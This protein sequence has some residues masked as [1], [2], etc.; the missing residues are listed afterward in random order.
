MT[1]TQTALPLPVPPMPTSRDID[2]FNTAIKQ[3]MSAPAMALSQLLDAGAQAVKSANTQAAS[4]MRSIPQ[5]PGIPMIQPPT[6]IPAP[7][8]T[9]QTTAGQIFPTAETEF[10]KLVKESRADMR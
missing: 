2:N 9:A 3:I 5:P 1:N 6:S 10:D 8:P 4:M 7:A